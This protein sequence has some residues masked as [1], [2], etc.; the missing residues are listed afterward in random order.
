ML[1]DKV[2][3]Y[4]SVFFFS[5]IMLKLSTYLCMYGILLYSYFQNM[6]IRGINEFVV[7]LESFRNIELWY[8]GLYFLTVTLHHPISNKKVPLLLLAR[9]LRNPSPIPKISIQHHNQSTSMISKSK[10]TPS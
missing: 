1:Y 5:N 4:K 8:Q 6:S 2:I 10:G 7:H 9:Y 3:L